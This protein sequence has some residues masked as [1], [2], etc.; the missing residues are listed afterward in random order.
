MLKKTML[1]ASMAVAA[2]AFALPAVASANWTHNTNAIAS[3]INLSFSGTASFVGELGGV[4]CSES[5]AT[6]EAT[7]GTKAHVKSFGADNPTTKCKASG[8]LAF[9]TVQTVEA[10]GLPWEAHTNTSAITVTT[11]HIDNTFSGA[12][13]PY[14]IITLY[15][16]VAVTPDNPHKAKTG[17][18]SG[19][20]KAYNGTSNA[21]IQN[22]T[23]SGT[24]NVT[25]SET[26][27][28]T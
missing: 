13:C 19:T 15:G 18:I 20:L 16:D 6:A 1:M 10:T 23:A 25:P 26:Y 14:H 4:S 5:T 24:L 8:G 2:I 27:G 3:P 9:C 22:V 11:V 17:T 28:I 12:F 7:V 21:F